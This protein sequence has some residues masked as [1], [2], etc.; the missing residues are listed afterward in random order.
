MRIETIVLSISLL[1]NAALAALIAVPAKDPPPSSRATVATAMADAAMEAPPPPSE[2]AADTSSPPLAPAAS[3][4]S[5]DAWV[6]DVRELVAELRRRG[7]DEGTVQRLGVA[8]AERLYRMAA[9]ALLQSAEESED[10][11]RVSEATRFRGSA[12]IEPPKLREFQRLRRE[13]IEMLGELFG[14]YEAV[15][16]EFNSANHFA[17]GWEQ[18]QYAY[19]PPDKRIELTEFFERQGAGADQ[20]PLQRYLSQQMYTPKQEIANE[21]K[22][23]EILG[24]ALFD[25]YVRQSSPTSMR[26]KYELAAFDP[27]RAEFDALLEVERAH[28]DTAEAPID[29]RQHERDVAARRDAIREVLGESRYADY[30]RATDEAYRHLESLARELGLGPPAARAAFAHVERARKQVLAVTGDGATIGEPKVQTALIEIRRETQKRVAQEM[31]L[32]DLSSNEQNMFLGPALNVHPQAIAR[33]MF[34]W[35]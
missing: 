28:L 22:V 26:L 23:K 31:G 15:A 17:W 13:R 33:R 27:T 35:N 1:A 12:G 16:T 5:K 21:E 14:D 20:T 18:D 24:P 30:E 19:A 29:P 4:H 2:T 34:R 10:Y 11:W 6:R 7:V 3:V 9:R 8:H 32:T 25:E